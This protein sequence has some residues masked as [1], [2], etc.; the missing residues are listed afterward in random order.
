MT[1]ETLRWAIEKIPFTGSS[2][3]V[4]YLI[5]KNLPAFMENHKRIA[6]AGDNLVSRVDTLN[7]NVE[8]VKIEM[9]HV[10]EK[11]GTVEKNVAQLASE[12][13][14]LKGRLS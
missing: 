9:K 3:F 5:L 8:N 13:K 1:E 12:I 7:G 11:I 14:D 10:T 4:L 2:L 6:I